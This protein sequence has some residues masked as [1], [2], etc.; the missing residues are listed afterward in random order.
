MY[1][2]A[3][4]S[5]GLHLN[6]KGE[7]LKTWRSYNREGNSWCTKWFH[8][9]G[10]KQHTHW[11]HNFVLASCATWCILHW[12]GQNDPN[13]VRKDNVITRK[14][15]TCQK[16]QMSVEKLCHRSVSSDNGPG[17][18][19]FLWSTSW[20]DSFVMANG[21]VSRIKHNCTDGIR[22]AV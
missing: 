22:W 17:L 14:L 12:G 4:N 13:K 15:N 5:R 18:S 1:I 9:W 7:T 3:A 6:L 19:D 16:T 20:K 8:I 10:W 11:E 21:G 2:P